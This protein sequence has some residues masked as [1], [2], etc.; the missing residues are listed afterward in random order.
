MNDPETKKDLEQMHKM[1]KYEMPQVSDVVSNF[2]TAN[3]SQAASKDKEGKK[4]QK[5]RKRPVARE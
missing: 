1:T 4:V 5:P 2:L 3:T